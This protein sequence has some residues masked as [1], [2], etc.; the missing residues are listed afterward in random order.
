M[1][2]LTEGKRHNA[3]IVPSCNSFVFQFFCSNAFTHSWLDWQTIFTLV[4]LIGKAAESD[5][6]SS[7]PRATNK[8][9]CFMCVVLMNGENLTLLFRLQEV[10][11]M[12]HEMSYASSFWTWQIKSF[13]AASQSSI[14]RISL[15]AGVFVTR[16]ENFELDWENKYLLESPLN[17]VVPMSIDACTCIYS[18][19]VSTQI[20]VWLT[21]SWNHNRYVW[22]T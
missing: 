20:A 8:E 7:M 17:N 9:G 11:G 16:N 22:S 14:R 18:C 4:K 12:L 21:P 5:T 1:K 13:V 3:V 15:L 2:V 6:I 10:I 19:N